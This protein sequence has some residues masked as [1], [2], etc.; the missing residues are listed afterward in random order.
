[1]QL[2]KHGIVNRSRTNQLDVSE[3]E[4]VAFLFGIDAI[5]KFKA[6]KGCYAVLSDKGAG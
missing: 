3:S 5:P 1:L 6:G 2:Q 4:A